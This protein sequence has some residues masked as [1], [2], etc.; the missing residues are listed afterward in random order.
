[1]NS[2]FSIDAISPQLDDNKRYNVREYRKEIYSVIPK[3]LRAP[4]DKKESYQ[5]GGYRKETVKSLP[6]RKKVSKTVEV[7][8]K[9]ETL[10]TKK[11]THSKPV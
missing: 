2:E 4:S 6:S 3:Q 9:V 7:V 10:T 8:P 5:N 1:M 11:R